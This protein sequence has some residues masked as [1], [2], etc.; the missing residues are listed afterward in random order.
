MKL[1]ELKLWQRLAALGVGVCGAFFIAI[2]VAAYQAAQV[3]DTLGAFVGQGV[4]RYGV[5]NNLYAQGLQ[6]GQAIRN[7]L[8]D[9]ANPK[10]HVNMKKAEDEF[11]GLL[12]QLA[13][14]DAGTD[15]KVVAELRNLNDANNAARA[16]VLALVKAGDGARA[17][18]ILVEKETPSWRKLKARLLDE[19]KA[20]DA[21]KASFKQEL[22][23]SI[24]QAK[25][26]VLGVSAVAVLLCVLLCWLLARS[27]QRQLG[28]EPT[29]ARE[30]THHIAAGDLTRE[31]NIRAGDRESLLAGMKRMQESLRKTVA[32]IKA[33]TDTIDVASVEIAQGNADLSQRTEEQASS[34]EET[35]SSME[36]LT[37]TVKQNADNARQANQL[38]ASASEVAL[39][40]GSVVGEVVGTMSAINDASKKIVDIIGVIDGIAFQ[41]N[42]LALNAAV[43]AARA[44]EQGRGFAVVASEVR[45]LAQRSATAAKE[46][47]ELIGNS[48]DKV[49]A[50]TKLVDEA[51]KTMEEIVGSV[52]RVTDIMAEI[53]A[54]SQEQSSGIE[55]VNRAIT[56]MD[57]VTQQNSALVEEASAAAQSM[58]EEAAQL[59]QAV[60]AFKLQQGAQSANE[61][62]PG[63]QAEKPAMLQVDRRGPNRATNVARLHAKPKPAP[64]KP[65]AVS[66]PAQAAPRK[67]ANGKAGEGEW[68]EF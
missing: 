53:T 56:Q 15:G 11:D 46:I 29:Y 61:T 9:P 41:T 3:E 66:A 13:G 68:E 37:S 50:G 43:E 45:S 47:K 7:I 65:A 6:R 58:K 24:G 16:E 4:A 51:G 1:S 60:A 17:K 27:L 48:V 21:S 42:I 34:L 14:L 31:V 23:A 54:A 33:S 25:A 67:L 62:Q 57:E 49:D 35:A 22:A 2:G 26:L 39:K 63:Q 19:L 32:Q 12:K 20:S 38:A 10:A 44:G 64:A 40:G 18:S 59:A 55:Q 52:K 5:L 28:G 8:L 36:E 30:V